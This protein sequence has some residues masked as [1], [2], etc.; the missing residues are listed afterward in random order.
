VREVGAVAQGAAL[1][2][3]WW[4]TDGAGKAGGGEPEARGGEPEEVRRV[5]RGAEMS[6]EQFKKLM[7][8]LKGL[9][10]TLDVIVAM[11]IVVILQG[12]L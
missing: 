4:G 12:C 7:H 2:L 8:H 5:W 9:D 10:T 11:L 6:E 1:L 3:W